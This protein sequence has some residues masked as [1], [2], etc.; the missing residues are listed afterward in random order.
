MGF[1][2]RIINW[3]KD[4]PLRNRFIKE[5]NDN[6]QSNFTNLTVNA[7]FKARS[8]FGNPD[9]RYRHEMSAPIMAS[10]FALEVIAGED[11]PQEDII[12]IGQIILYNENI[13]RWLWA[14]HWDTRIV[15]DVRSGKTGQ[16][17]IKDFV[18]LGGLLDA[19]RVNFN[20]TD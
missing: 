18:H 10:G 5:F 4:Y 8:C 16:W 14:L 6:A 2:H 12:M 9:P 15:K 11:V 3:F 13:V 19:V 17:A 20:I 7:L 1:F